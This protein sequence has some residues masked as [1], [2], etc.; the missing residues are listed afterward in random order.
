MHKSNNE[1]SKDTICTHSCPTALRAFVD[2]R[3]VAPNPPS[4]LGHKLRYAAKMV[5]P[6]AAVVRE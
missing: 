4:K 5:D 6:K 3:R 1:H 2:V